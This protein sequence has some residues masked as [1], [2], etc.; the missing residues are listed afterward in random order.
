MTMILRITVKPLFLSLDIDHPNQ[1]GMQQGVEG[2][3]NGGAGKRRGK[4]VRGRDRSCQPWDGWD[5]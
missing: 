4:Q 1:P 5:G 2:V 3:V